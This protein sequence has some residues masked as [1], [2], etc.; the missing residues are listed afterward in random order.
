MSQPDSDAD[1]DQPEIDL[2]DPD[3]YH[4]TQRLKEIHR[5]RQRVH[6]AIDGFDYPDKGSDA[7]AQRQR[8]AYAVS[9]YV[10]ELENVISDTDADASL[11]DHYPWSDVQQYAD[12][13]GY[14]PADF[15]HETNYAPKRDSIQ[16]FRK[17]NRIL[18][19]LKPLIEQQEDT[20]WEV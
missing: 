7:R 10:S 6:K 9:M 19:D 4:R 5:A 11:P 2:A 18:A 1:T 15:D 8:L 12:T 20:E 3:D 17:C 14:I 13:L 16:V